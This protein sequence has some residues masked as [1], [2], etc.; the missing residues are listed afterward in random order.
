MFLGMELSFSY[1]HITIV[2]P[3]FINHTIRPVIQDRHFGVI[4][5][6]NFLDQV[7]S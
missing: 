6:S 7:K 3:S 2:N 1:P 4:V 5:T